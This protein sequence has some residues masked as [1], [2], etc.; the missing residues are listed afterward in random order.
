MIPQI[1]CFIK[2]NTLNRAFVN[3]H[4]SSC[5]KYIS[6][7]FSKVLQKMVRKEHAEFN[8]CED[9]YTYISTGGP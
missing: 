5:E 7:S 3:E 4:K 9:I 1:T 8:E 6:E 2:K